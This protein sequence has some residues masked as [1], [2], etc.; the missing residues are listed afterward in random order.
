MDVTERAVLTGVIV[1]CWSFAFCILEPIPTLW[2]FPLEHRWAITSRPEGL[3]M[4]WY[5]RTLFSLF[6]SMVL[7]VASLP[8]L[9]RHA[10]PSPWTHRVW[11]GVLVVSVLFAVSVIVWTH[12]GGHPVA[13]PLPPGYTPK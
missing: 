12:L 6:V 1:F 7:S 13:E 8:L 4:D 11:T 10:A 2:Y 5:G 9:R 3:A